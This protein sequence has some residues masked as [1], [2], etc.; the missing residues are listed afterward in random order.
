MSPDPLATATAPKRALPRGACDTHAHV[1]GPYDR[2]PLA[3]ERSYTP[4]EA[5]F[6]T[7]IGMLDRVGFSR[8]VLVH[9]SAYGLD[10]SAMLD[11]LNRAR[12]RLR[13]IAVT[14]ASIADATLASMNAQ[15]VRGV[16]FTET[17][18]PGAQK[19]AGSVGL[20]EFDRLAPRVRELG[21]H[22]QIWIECD[23]FVAAAPR[24]LRAGIPL[25]IDHMGRFDV[26]RGTDNPAFRELLRLVA[27]ENIW[28][29][30]SAPRNSQRFPDYEDVRPFHEALLRANPDRL[31]WGSDWPFLRMGDKT[32]EVGHLVDLFDAW[33]SDESLRR[34][35]MVDNPATLYGFAALEQIN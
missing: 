27:N 30:L 15:G 20:E 4:P 25:V 24:L 33:T 2:F 11:A 16:R 18:G 1:F 23:A 6:E 31:L 8:G 34:K 13:G 32:P 10:C 17:S 22:A 35:I 5:P 3:A 28:I 19:F 21:W 14:D 29:K 7:Y 12:D 9:P 26:T